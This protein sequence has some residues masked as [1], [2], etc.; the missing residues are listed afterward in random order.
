M[1]TD[2]VPGLVPPFEI[3]ANTSR[4]KFAVVEVTRWQ[5]EG[6]LTFEDVKD[7]MRGT[8]GEQLAVKHYLGILR[9]STYVAVLP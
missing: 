4:P 5:P 6:E 2:T 3:N 8:L 1:R 7:R 9:R